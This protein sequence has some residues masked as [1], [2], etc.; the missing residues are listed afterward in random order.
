MTLGGEVGHL[1]FR[2][3]NAFYIKGG[4]LASSGLLI[5]PGVSVA[6]NV[7]SNIVDSTLGRIGV[8]PEKEVRGSLGLQ[9]TSP[10]G[11]G[12]APTASYGSVSDALLPELEGGLFDGRLH[13]WIPLSRYSR[14]SLL[15]LH[16][17]PP[18][19]DSFTTFGLGFTVGVRRTP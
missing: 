7:G 1:F 9:Y 17:S 2:D 15:L 3:D 16:Q 10:S 14:V 19:T 13:I 5:T 11:F 4:I 8:I 12:I 6:N 18:S